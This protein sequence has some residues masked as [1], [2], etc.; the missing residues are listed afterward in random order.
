M[1]LIIIII[2]ILILIIFSFTINKKEIE[3]LKNCN[4]NLMGN[5]S[6]FCTWNINSQKCYCSFQP[7]L[8]RTNFPQNPNCCDIQCNMLSEEEC[9][10]LPNTKYSNVS[11]YCPIN[12][13]CKEVKGYTRDNNISANICG[14]DNLNYQTIYPFLTKYDCE[15]SLDPCSLN[16]NPKYSDNQKKQKCLE[17][18]LCGW[19]I[20]SQDVGQCIEGTSAGPLNIFKYNFCKLNKQGNN[21]YQ[22]N[23]DPKI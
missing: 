20:N 10:K 7:G 6:N 22:Y 11:F 8:V 5:R 19:C 3:N 16:N 9:V 21:S 15:K 12:G 2:I 18:N 23:S 17:N 1:I 13:V 4:N 14:Y